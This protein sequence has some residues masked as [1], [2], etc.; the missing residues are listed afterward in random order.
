MMMLTTTIKA[1][2]IMSASFLGLA[3]L[4][5]APSAYA[6]AKTT[7]V[8]QVKGQDLEPWCNGSQPNGA[9][10]T[11]GGT[12]S[13][14]LLAQAAQDGST[15][16]AVTYRLCGQWNG[17]IYGKSDYTT[18]QRGDTLVVENYRLLQQAITNG[19]F[20]KGRLHTAVYDIES[21][22]YT[23]R[24]Q[25]N[26]P[27]KAITKALATARKARV[28]LIVTPGGKLARCYKCWEAAAE[29][30]A[31]GVA[32]QSQAWDLA[33]W[34]TFTAQAVADVRNTRKTYGTA[35]FAMLGLATNT[36]RINSV[37]L[38]KKEYNYATRAEKVTHFWMNANN[39]GQQNLCKQPDGGP[40]CPQIAV[41]FWKDEGLTGSYVP[42]GLS[43]SPSRGLTQ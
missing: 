39:W 12:Q 26:D 13:A 18:C 2:A 25:R 11:S 5:V 19:V 24:R 16:P 3:V 28:G 1:A 30:G 36:P 10:C 6:A 15:L 41:Q 22:P 38:L 31:L 32:I 35:T 42:L 37:K 27:V 4:S 33:T 17:T 40:G 7:I 20:T 9:E 34:Y 23:P 21:W 14:G 29:H 43:R 8:W